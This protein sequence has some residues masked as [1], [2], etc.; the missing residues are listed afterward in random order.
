MWASSWWML[1][2]WREAPDTHSMVAHCQPFCQALAIPT[3]Q[4]LPSPQNG[5]R[6]QEACKGFISICAEKAFACSETK[7]FVLLGPEPDFELWAEFRQSP[8]AAELVAFLE[9]PAGHCRGKQLGSS[10]MMLHQSCPWATWYQWQWVVFSW[11]IWLA[12]GSALS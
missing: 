2:C 6:Q 12:D 4:M 9:G 1:F 10:V 3:P 5:A 8:V 7:L 11:M